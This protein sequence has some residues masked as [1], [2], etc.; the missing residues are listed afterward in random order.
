[1]EGHYATHPSQFM[2]QPSFFYYNPDPHADNRQHGRFTPHPAHG[3]PY[4]HQLQS[5]DP[6]AYYTYGER[7]A[8][9]SSHMHYHQMP[10]YHQQPLMTPLASPQPLYQKPTILVQQESP[11]LYPLETDCYAP[12]T[13]P[14]SCSGSAVS[15]PPSACEILPT[16]VH[17]AFYANESF[18]GVKQGREEGVYSEILSGGEFTRSSSP[19]LTPGMCIVV[20]DVANVSRCTGLGITALSS[21]R[22]TRKQCLSRCRP[23]PTS[24]PPHRALRSPPHPHHFHVQQPQKLNSSS[25]ILEI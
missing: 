11:Y 7:P 6:A 15:S 20:C 17:A 19:P 24:F 25:A 3:L 13:P 5:H 18:E 23:P 8:S 21:A 12:S 9:A 10:Q 4:S 2:G 16:P 14:L 22:L 1:M